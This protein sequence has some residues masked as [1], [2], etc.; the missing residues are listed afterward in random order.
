MVEEI[1]S[2]NIK[3]LTNCTAYPAP[4]QWISH[5]QLSDQNLE[6]GRLTYK[7]PSFSKVSGWTATHLPRVHLDIE[8]II[9]LNVLDLVDPW[10]EPSTL[11]EDGRRSTGGV[12]DHGSQ[13]IC[14]QR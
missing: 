6:R 12:W 2:D 10:L 14:E 9:S 4:R 13:K 1:T 11:V 7:S 3:V 8:V 5:F